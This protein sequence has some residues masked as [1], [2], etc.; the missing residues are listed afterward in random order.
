M[1]AGRL[2]KGLPRRS[3]CLSSD[4]V[5]KLDEVRHAANRIEQCREGVVTDIQIAKPLQSGER[6]RERGQA[7][8]VK[9]EEIRE[10]I[11]IAQ[12]IGQAGQ[13]VVSEVQHAKSF[14]FFGQLGQPVVGQ[15]ASSRDSGATPMD[16]A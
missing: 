8:V 14:D 16:G 12:R 11:E 10:A 2:V 15:A 3:I 13:L 6:R 5:P 4:R 7:V 9:V 1:P